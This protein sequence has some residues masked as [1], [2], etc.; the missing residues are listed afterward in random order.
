MPKPRRA[1]KSQAIG[2]L[3]R[4]DYG[5][6]ELRQRLLTR[7]W[8]EES[9]GGADA[10]VV[11]TLLDELTALG[12]LSDERYAHALVARKQGSH[13]ARSI[14]GTLKAQGVDSAIATE[15]LAGREGDDD[16]AM[17]A[18]WERRFGNAPADEREKARQ[19][20]FLQSRGFALSSILQFLR[21]QPVK[22]S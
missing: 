6:A 14:A 19:V 17:Q 16:T 2:L 12:L 7:A 18:L 1:L 21:C 3:A 8:G 13:S 4:R 5:R 22:D 20:R 11:D 15:A 9:R 10:S